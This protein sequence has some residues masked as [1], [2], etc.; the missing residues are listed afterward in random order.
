MVIDRN[1]DAGPHYSYVEFGAYNELS[2]RNINDIT[3]MENLAGSYWGNYIT[4]F[5]FGSSSNP[6]QFPETTVSWSA[7]K[8]RLSSGWYDIIGPVA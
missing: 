4:G 6:S 7:Q 1:T 2:M 5:K 3:W 8:A